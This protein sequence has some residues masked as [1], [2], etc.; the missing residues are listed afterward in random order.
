[1]PGQRAEAP[2]VD[3]RNPGL[4][5][6]PLK[7]PSRDAKIVGSTGCN[8]LL[9]IYRVR[10]DQIIFS[11]GLGTT[12]M[13]CPPGPAADVEQAFGEALQFS[14]RFHVTGGHLEIFDDAGKLLLRFRAER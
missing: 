11:P 6:N 8:R 7:P 14:S 4:L 1:V 9:G 13:A 12:R 10:D 2:P 5:P 3:E